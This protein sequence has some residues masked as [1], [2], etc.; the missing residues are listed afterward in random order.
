MTVLRFCSINENSL[1]NI[2]TVVIIWKKVISG[3]G[4]I[5]L[6]VSLEKTLFTFCPTSKNKVRLKSALRRLPLEEKQKTMK[7]DSLQ[8]NMILATKWIMQ[9]NTL[10][11]SIS[12][13]SRSKSAKTQRR[14]KCLKMLLLDQVLTKYI[15]TSELFNFYIQFIFTYF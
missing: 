13:S 14:T 3:L 6:K 5:L 12:Q 7:L 11:L 2:D 9:V 15:A 8:F 1:L 4:S 10:T